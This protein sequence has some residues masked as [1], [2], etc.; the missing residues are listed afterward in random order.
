MIDK[1][2]I[3]K[4]GILYACIC[5]LFIVHHIALHDE[6]MISY[7][8]LQYSALMPIATV[9]ETAKLCYRIVTIHIPDFILTHLPNLLNKIWMFIRD[10]IITRIH[11]LLI[12]IFDVIKTISNYVLDFLDILY[13]IAVAIWNFFVDWIIQPIYNTLKKLVIALID[14]LTFVKDKLVF[15]INFIN[16][17]VI[18]P[19][20][21]VIQKVM[22]IFKDWILIPFWN[23][24]KSICTIIKDWILTPLWN[25][26][27]HIVEFLIYDLPP[28]LRYIFEKVSNFLKWLG[29]HII[30]TI[31][32]I[33]DIVTHVFEKYIIPFLNWLW[34]ILT[35]VLELVKNVVTFIWDYICIPLYEFFEYIATKFGNLFK[36][37][38]ENIIVPLF[39]LCE[40]LGRWIYKIL[41]NII[42]KIGVICVE[43]FEKFI[44]CCKIVQNIGAWIYE[45]I[46]QPIWDLIV[47]VTN[48]ILNI[49]QHIWQFLCDAYNFVV[50]VLSFVW[51][52][53]MWP[54]LYNTWYM[55]STITRAMYNL[56]CK[57]ALMIY[58][59]GIQIYEMFIKFWNVIVV[60]IFNKFSEV[61][62]KCCD[63]ASAV[64]NS[65]YELMVSLSDVWFKA[66]DLF[67]KMVD[68]MVS[69]YTNF[70][71]IVV[72]FFI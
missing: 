33:I 34:D 35:N 29:D 32:N 11:N 72:N 69:I 10:N 68:K 55:I 8:V 25:I 53:L 20:I 67:S 12:V 13:D 59:L 65:M 4:L 66:M 17:W 26:I 49:L 71:N 37:L 19:V 52:E 6:E 46:M 28:I 70:T 44:E 38:W 21:N 30:K 61:F 24:L 22:N 1:S 50:K 64:F 36:K 45:K 23:L 15:I 14:V 9:W 62:W 54:F 3:K 18:A 27:E 7:Q 16:E 47:I 58:N 5:A 51:Y 2:Y 57:C 41:S 40:K 42:E 43:I 39:E 60:P 31:R 48:W 63:V 56:F